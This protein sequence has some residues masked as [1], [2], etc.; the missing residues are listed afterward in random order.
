VLSER[1]LYCLYLAVAHLESCRYDCGML[2]LSRF[3][4]LPVIFNIGSWVFIN[5]IVFAMF[6]N[7]RVQLVECLKQAG[8]ARFVLP[9]EA[10]HVTHFDEV[11]IPRG[12]VVSYMKCDEFHWLPALTFPVNVSR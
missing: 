12:V 3:D 8:L 2:P 5:H 7:D 9:H 1:I 11:R 4:C 6:W 10:C